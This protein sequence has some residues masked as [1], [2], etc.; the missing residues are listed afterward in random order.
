MKKP[1]SRK[2]KLNTTSQLNSHSPKTP[3]QSLPLLPKKKRKFKESPK[4]PDE[5]ERKITYLNVEY[6]YDDKKVIQ[7][8]SV[9][10]FNR[11]KKENN[12]SKII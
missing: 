2:F 6:I 1:S 3:N 12:D 7:F 8:N 10:F 4:Y 9:E 11:R 5:N